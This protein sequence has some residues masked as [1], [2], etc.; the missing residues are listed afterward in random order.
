MNVKN[1]QE[2]SDIRL[3][4]LE[5]QVLDLAKRDSLKYQLNTCFWETWLNIYHNYLPKSIKTIIRFIR[6]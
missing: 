4:Y 2:K 1:I 6:K 3:S 5:E